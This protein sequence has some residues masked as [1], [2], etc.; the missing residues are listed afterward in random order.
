VLSITNNYPI[1][2]CSNDCL[3]KSFSYLSLL[4]IKKISSVNKLWNNL[5]NIEFVKDVKPLVAREA[6]GS[7]QWMVFLKEHCKVACVDEELSLLPKNIGSILLSPSL[8]FP[9]LRTFETDI[10]LFIR[11]GISIT[12]A[13]ENCKK[14]MPIARGFPYISNRMAKLAR[15]KIKESYWILLTKKALPE[16]TKNRDLFDKI[17][18]MNA[19]SEKTNGNYQAPLAIEI[20]IG[21]LAHYSRTGEWLYK[22]TG[23]LTKDKL[24]DKEIVVK[25]LTQSST[26][27]RTGPF[28]SIFTFSSLAGI[29]AVW[30][31]NKNS[32][33][34]KR[35]YRSLS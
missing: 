7:N 14:T 19:Y 6:I 13:Y 22:E 26:E 8:A 16:T 23:S 32:L 27:N 9:G 30:N 25:S 3:S 29:A 10:L 1:Y 28:L 20:Y 18:A 5:A 12:E 2:T 33:C 15:V 31:L 4:E 17:N 24:R 11:A 21:I 34:E 35:V